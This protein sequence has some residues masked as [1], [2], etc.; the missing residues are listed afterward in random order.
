MKL[1][2]TDYSSASPSRLLQEPRLS[3]ATLITLSQWRPIALNC[4]SVSF[5]FLFP[6]PSL[7]FVYSASSQEPH[8]INHILLL[9]P[10]YDPVG[11]INSFVSDT[12]AS[13]SD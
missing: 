13:T 10:I 5:L 1:I 11:R 6:F 4:L 8:Q 7:L 9:H 2:R 3:Q 12:G